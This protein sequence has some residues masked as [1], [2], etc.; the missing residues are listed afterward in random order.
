MKL[1]ERS[2]SQTLARTTGVA[3]VTKAKFVKFVEVQDTEKRRDPT[4]NQRDW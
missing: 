2:A 1:R 3:E 4:Q